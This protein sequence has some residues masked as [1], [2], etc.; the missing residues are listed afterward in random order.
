MPLQ[1]EV[2]SPEEDYWLLYIKALEQFFLIL[3]KD[4]YDP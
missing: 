3:G 1:Q 4:I 2:Y